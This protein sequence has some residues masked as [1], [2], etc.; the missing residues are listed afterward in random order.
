MIPNSV[1]KKNSSKKASQALDPGKVTRA[2]VKQIVRSMIDQDTEQKY[3]Y[4][5][6]NPPSSNIHFGG[7]IASVSDMAQ[8]IADTQRVGDQIIAESFQWGVSVC[9]DGTHT[10]LD[11]SKSSSTVRLI[12]FGWKPFFNVAPPAAGNILLF[13]GEECAAVS[14]YVHDGRNQFILYSDQT[15]VVDWMNQRHN[16]YGKVKLN[17][18]IQFTTASTTAASHKLFYLL[19]SDRDSSGACPQLE[20]LFTNLLYSDA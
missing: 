4:T 20:Y 10:D 19:I 8:G 15:A 14:P 9:Y 1:R 7:T 16:F 17:Q 18:K 2:Q 12:I 13:T 6:V 11:C 3:H 5:K